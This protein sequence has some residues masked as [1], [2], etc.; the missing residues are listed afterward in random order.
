MSEPM[1][2]MRDLVARDRSGPRGAPR[3]SIAVASLELGAGVVAILGAPQDGAVAL[4][5]VLSGR[6]RPERGRVLVA[7]GDPARDARTRLRIGAVGLEPTLPEARTVEAS[8]DIAQSAAATPKPGQ[9]VL[10][11]AGLGAL[12]ARPLAS[13]STGERRAVELAIAIAVEAPG[14]IVVHEPFSD[15]ARSA[16]ETFASLDALGRIA[17]VV[18]ITASP[19]DARRFARV[20][21]LTRGVLARETT[22]PHA[23]LGAPLAAHLIAWVAQGARELAAALAPREEVASLI[24]S[25]DAPGGLAVV[26]LAGTDMDA[27]SRAFAEAAATSAADVE[28]LRE[29]APSLA[30]ITAMTEWELR[31]RQLTA[32]HVA[33]A[34]ARLRAELGAAEAA[35][36]QA[37][38][39]ARAGH[40]P[41]PHD[42]AGRA[43]AWGPAAPAEISPG[44]LAPKPNGAGEPPAGGSQ[45]GAA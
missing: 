31:A 26:R 45:G 1:V 25:A 21:V 17:P 33:Q 43:P 29:V 32:M 40:H 3:G 38:Y 34:D 4:F 13:L 24:L 7:G 27:L 15:M 35:A 16:D 10:E 9:A 22:G 44:V 19:A 5:E 2:V 30:E 39:A 18:V 37:A 41:P 6:R 8:V 36:R 11:A 12:A 28:I 42:P 14:L 23:A 20:I